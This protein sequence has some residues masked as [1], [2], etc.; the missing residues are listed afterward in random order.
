[1]R[2][3]GPIRVVPVR[4]KLPLASPWRF[5][6]QGDEF[7][8]APRNQIRLG[9]LSFHSS[10]SWTHQ[11]GDRVTRLAPPPSMSNDWTH[12]IQIS[13]LAEGSFLKTSRLSGKDLF[14]IETPSLHKLVL[15]LVMP[16]GSNTSVDLPREVSSGTKLAVLPLRSGATVLIV[17]RLVRATSADLARVA[18]LNKQLELTLRQ[19]SDPKAFFAEL[20]L[21]SYR[22]ESGNVLQIFPVSQES[23]SVEPAG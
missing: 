17:A 20:V 22:P 23:I 18:E 11:I 14:L 4:N 12:V 15:D 16:S 7:Y 21:Q 8:A 13:F 10:G 19:G 3:R 1:M 5:W 6:S 2:T 9:K